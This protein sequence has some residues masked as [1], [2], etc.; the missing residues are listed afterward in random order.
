MKHTYAH[1]LNSVK[2]VLQE[3]NKTKDLLFIV[4]AALHMWES[5]IDHNNNNNKNVSIL[6]N[7]YL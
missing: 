2:I 6:K 4:C 3:T 5:V 1:G 7:N